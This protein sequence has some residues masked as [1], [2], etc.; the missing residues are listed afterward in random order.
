MPG[1][2]EVQFK[3]SAEDEA[4]EQ[5]KTVIGTIT[6]LVRTSVKNMNA[7]EYAQEQL[8]EALEE[9][10]EYAKTAF[11]NAIEWRKQ[12]IKYT[13]HLKDAQERLTEEVEQYADVITRVSKSN[14]RPGRGVDISHTPGLMDKGISTYDEKNVSKIVGF[15]KELI[16]DKKRLLELEREINQENKRFNSEYI[17][18]ERERIG[19]AKQYASA[20]E[21][22]YKEIRQQ[23][24]QYDSEYRKALNEREQQEKRAIDEV[25]QHQ[26]AAQE[27]KK[28]LA[29]KTAKEIEQYEKGERQRED[30][31]AW[32][33]DMER[34]ALA[35]HKKRNARIEAEQKQ[36][37]AK[38]KSE[39]ERFMKYQFSVL[40][41]QK[42]VP[43]AVQQSMKQFGDLGQG[44]FD[45]INDAAK[46]YNKTAEDTK[47][48]NKEQE[49]GLSKLV[50]A[51]SKVNVQYFTYT[52]ILHDVEFGFER[53]ADFMKR[54]ARSLIDA[55]AEFETFERTVLATEA[56]VGAAHKRLN[57]II[58]LGLELVGVSTQSMIKYNAQLRAAGVSAKQVDMILTGVAKSMAELGKGT[59]ATE[60]VLLQLT[61]AIAGNKIVL[62]DLRPIL[63]ETPG[64][65]RAATIA[66]G[67]VIQSTEMLREA[68]AAK[69]IEKR[70]GL[71]LI[72]E[73]INKSAR[74]A[75]M[76]TYAAQIDI[77][78]D[79][80]FL[81]RAELGKQLLPIMVGTI[82]ILNGM[83][84][85]FNWLHPIVKRFVSGG[86]IAMTAALIFFN[87]AVKTAIA[88][89]TAYHTVLG[90]QVFRNYAAA[91]STAAVNTTAFGVAAAGTGKVIRTMLPA[92]SIAIG[93]ITAL[94]LVFTFMT[95]SAKRNT[96]ALDEAKTAFQEINKI[97]LNT[98]ALEDISISLQERINEIRKSGDYNNKEGRA[99]I[100]D[101]SENIRFI[102]DL[103]SGDEVKSVA[104]LTKRIK[105]AR[106]ELQSIKAL[107]DNIR[108]GEVEGSADEIRDKWEALRF[109]YSQSAD[110]L[111]LLEIRQK[112]VATSTV[113]MAEALV[114]AAFAVKR[115][116]NTF[117]RE[118]QDARSIIGARDSL[119]KAVKDENK[120]LLQQ[121]KLKSHERLE[122]LQQEA[123][124]VIRINQE[125][126][127]SL[128][129]LMEDNRK[130]LKGI[131]TGLAK[132]ATDA[133]K[134]MSNRIK[135]HN[136]SWVNHV[137]S[138][139]K[140]AEA[141]YKKLG[142]IMKENSEKY[143]PEKM[144]EFAL[145][146]SKQTGAF[147][148]QGFLGEL[149]NAFSIE[150][151]EERNA[152]IVSISERLRTKLFSITELSNDEK[153][154]IISDFTEKVQ[155][156]QK[157]LYNA[158]V[159]NLQGIKEYHEYTWGELS[160]G[161]SRVY[162][163]IKGYSIANLSDMKNAS[164]NSLSEFGIFL[165]NIKK[166]YE[167]A[168]KDREK[169]EKQRKK[170]L[171]KQV[172]AESKAAEKIYRKL[173]DSAIE[174]LFERDKSFAEVAKSFL[175]YSLRI[176]AQ[177]FIETQIR[178]SNQKRLQQEILKTNILKTGSG[179]AGDAAGLLSG[180][181]NA[182]KGGAAGTPFASMLSS[183]G[184]PA[185]LKS[186]LAGGGVALGGASLIAPT[187]VG[188]AFSGA[189]GALKDLFKMITDAP[190][191]ID[192]NKIG[193]VFADPVNDRLPYASGGQMAMEQI[194][195][196]A[197]QSAQ[198]QQA[199]FNSSFESMFERL[200][201]GAAGGQPINLTVHIGG[202]EL[203][204]FWYEIEARE[205][206]DRM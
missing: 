166:P 113:D 4:S 88:G 176:L 94:S 120:L 108:R 147:K 19:L 77:L 193:D 189:G 121:D 57:D 157:I 155:E 63:E 203:R 187:E 32:L 159:N 110:A 6:A 44:A 132:D 102:K 206:E 201:G 17:S 142:K 65:W 51:L 85:I 124:D 101:L 136:R 15:T 138:V 48:K 137:K 129:D 185:F 35:A 30:D 29:R 178:I 125:A 162:N 150:D 186:S 171:K 7:L 127:D 139:T 38:L 11:R 55:G 58:E 99:L 71:L 158:E 133:H 146:G 164:K 3:I 114:Y 82:K 47:K 14:M 109:E 26:R 167:Q 198:D 188:N 165:D 123:F 105:E 106:H 74:G 96:E 24:N 92:V 41:K 177:D 118:T 13:K 104:A 39:F 31:K 61:Q 192:P 154:K 10:N 170:D 103:L 84:K 107:Q 67:E 183:A 131:H 169:S 163:I 134:R 40:A 122:I 45:K 86:I 116:Q 50:K 161:W 9:G 33:R 90:V 156:Y 76:E 8:S 197:S 141:E 93:L 126:N 204:D 152:K 43:A 115:A 184:I 53:G 52:N 83:I 2:D 174:L 172:E 12:E 140:E 202:R 194:K 117:S 190:G 81:F 60:R 23:H 27:E 135:Q 205:E 49:Q 153:D 144:L 181:G 22:A 199:L 168:L 69:G 143:S 25:V 91:T 191:K 66:M 72:M 89:I 151:A 36:H 68:I 180:A 78:K 79:R 173:S 59:A 70:A 196:N 130:I 80:F 37:T 200:Q 95:K 98:A 56:N 100:A 73:Q 111:K 62:Q 1:N 42:G 179:G 54:M 16:A 160:K 119:I 20:Y 148:D 182:L 18:A 21:N 149:K 28:Q 5:L 64:F 195:K 175:K 112:S 128:K 34:E 75:D 145:Q 87:G 97:I 46:K